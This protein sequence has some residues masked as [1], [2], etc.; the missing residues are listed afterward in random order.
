MY[1]L[2]FFKLMMMPSKTLANN[3]MKDNLVIKTSYL[4]SLVGS[5]PN[6]FLKFLGI[7]QKRNSHKL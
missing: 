3:K 1:G 2:P 6:S 4:V 7:Y 5:Q